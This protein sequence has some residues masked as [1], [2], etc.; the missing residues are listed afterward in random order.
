MSTGTILAP[1]LFVTMTHWYSRTP[2][3]FLK[4]KNMKFLEQYD[5]NY[6]KFDIINCSKAA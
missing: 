1:M 3:E 4:C 2:V 6:V 5:N